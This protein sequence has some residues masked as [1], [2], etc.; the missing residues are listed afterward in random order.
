MK[1]E[2]CGYKM[3]IL[4]TSYA[5]DKCDGCIEDDDDDGSSCGDFSASDIDELFESYEDWWN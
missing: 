1:C 5:C 3:T 2:I 4:L